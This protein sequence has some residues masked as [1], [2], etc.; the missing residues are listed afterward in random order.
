MTI[1][2]G[3]YKKA[4]IDKIEVGQ[5]FMTEY[6]QKR[7]YYI[8]INSYQIEH[9]YAK[10]YNVFNALNLETGLLEYIPYTTDIVVIASQLIFYY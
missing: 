1:Q 5:T 10:G 7:K 9:L 6:L 3:N 4:T 8:K 2:C